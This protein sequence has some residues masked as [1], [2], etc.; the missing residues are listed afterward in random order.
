MYTFVCLSSKV[1]DFSRMGTSGVASIATLLSMI[2]VGQ[3]SGEDVPPTAF[4]LCKLDQVV[5]WDIQGLLLA[6]LGQC[7]SLVTVVNDILKGF[8]VIFL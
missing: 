2:N 3:R 8:L 6:P 1:E 5:L 4:S 7:S